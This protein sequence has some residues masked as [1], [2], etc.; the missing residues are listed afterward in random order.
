MSDRRL[1]IRATS[2]LALTLL[3]AAAPAGAVTIFV[4]N[5]HGQVTDTDGLFEGDSDPFVE[6]WIDG[7]LAGI[8]PTIQGTN[9]PSWP[10]F[11][12]ALPITPGPGNTPLVTV[13]LRVYDEEMVPMPAQYQGVETH[14]YAWQNGLPVTVNGPIVGPFALPAP[15]LYATLRVEDVVPTSGAT[16]GG[17]L[18]LFR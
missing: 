12:C 4:E 16:W 17:V 7:Q 6:V 8:T 15:G 3:L 13:E 1:A 5:I 14:Q 2:L 10:A 9:N 18:A 11:S